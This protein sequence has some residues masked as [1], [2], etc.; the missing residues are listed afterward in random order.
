MSLPERETGMWAA[1]PPTPTPARARTTPRSP[2]RARR[3][4]PAARRRSTGGTSECRWVE[5]DFILPMMLLGGGVADGRPADL[6][7][8]VKPERGDVAPKSLG[9]FCGSVCIDTGF[10]FLRP[11]ACHASSAVL[12]GRSFTHEYVRA[13][14]GV[15]AGFQIIAR[16]VTAL[17]FLFTVSFFMASFPKVT[18]RISLAW[19]NYVNAHPQH[20]SSRCPDFSF[21]ICVAQSFVSF[22]LG[23]PGWCTQRFQK[24]VKTDVQ[25][26]RGSNTHRNIFSVASR[27]ARSTV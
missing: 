17:I 16:V 21:F 8:S 18:A 3:H 11:C 4:C 23:D 26:G 13:A 19:C 6:K 27:L 15:A 25:M 9:P 12:G 20:A 22:V 2:P 24:G 5:R 7:R 10:V 1:T 14:A